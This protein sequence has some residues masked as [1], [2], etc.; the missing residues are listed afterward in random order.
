MEKP[1]HCFPYTNL[2][3][4]M[5]F[6]TVDL[7][8]H[9][10]PNLS[11]CWLKWTDIS[12]YIELLKTSELYNCSPMH[13]VKFLSSQQVVWHPWMTDMSAFAAAMMEKL[14][15]VE[16]QRLIYDDKNTPADTQ[17]HLIQQISDSSRMSC[18]HLR[19]KLDEW[20][21]PNCERRYKKMHVG[22]E[23]WTACLSNTCKKLTTFCPSSTFK[24]RCSKTQLWQ[25][26][27]KWISG[28]KSWMLQSKLNNPNAKESRACWKTLRLPV[29]SGRI[30]L[31]RSVIHCLPEWKAD[32]D[33]ACSSAVI[34]QVACQWWLMYFS[35]AWSGFCTCWLAVKSIFF[36]SKV[37]LGKAS[38]LPWM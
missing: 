17:L 25:I 8:F 12:R 19:R 20:R 30:Q 13:L 21:T 6:I 29:S 14:E 16:K 3:S 23:A 7:F 34:V 9:V 27:V 36:S 1:V 37:P 18:V 35:R 11:L 4:S 28:S 5:F 22:G 15:T 26:V 33:W 2:F 10:R 38:M 32:E 24:I 31:F